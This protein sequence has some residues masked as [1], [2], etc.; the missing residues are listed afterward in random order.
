MPI[1]MTNSAYVLD[2]N[3]L[4]NMIYPIGAVYIST[5]DVNPESLFGGEWISIKD[6]FLFASG[7]Y[8]QVDDI[9]GEAEVVLDVTN[10]PPHNHTYSVPAIIGRRTGD[11]P[12]VLSVAETSSVGNNQP[13]NN[14]PPYKVVNIWRRTA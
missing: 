3:D 1:G 13:H 7:E 6:R 2:S 10:M 8:S 14:M 4:L 9:G 5:Q 11:W 12:A